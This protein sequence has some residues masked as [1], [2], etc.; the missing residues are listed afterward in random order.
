[1]AVSGT[2]WIQDE[3]WV[4]VKVDNSRPVVPES[5]SDRVSGFSPYA[6]WVQNDAVR[7]W[8]EMRDTAPIAWSEQFGGFWVLTRHE[9]VRRPITPP[10]V[11]LT[12]SISSS[13]Q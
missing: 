5:L 9:D 6:A 11:V 1:M 3:R 8:K 10:S 2:S 4:S 12:T 7:Y 13:D